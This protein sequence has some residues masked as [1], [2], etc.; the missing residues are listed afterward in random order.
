MF[1]VSDDRGRKNRRTAHWDKYWG[2]RREHEGG[3]GVEKEEDG[4]KGGDLFAL[5]YDH[6]GSLVRWARD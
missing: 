4:E 1:V 6:P 5:V 3:D 2:V